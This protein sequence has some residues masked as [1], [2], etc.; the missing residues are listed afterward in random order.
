MIR[1]RERNR[2][3]RKRNRKEKKRKKEK[4]TMK[5]EWSKNREIDR[6]FRNL[7]FD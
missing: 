3:E 4:D 5:K 1:T 6:E 7:K 2:K